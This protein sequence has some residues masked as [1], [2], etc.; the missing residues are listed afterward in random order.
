MLPDSL[1]QKDG[2]VELKD[3]KYVVEGGK[4]YST[5][6]IVW[7]PLY[8]ENEHFVLLSSCIVGVRNGGQE[9]DDWLKNT[10]SNLS[11]TEEETQAFKEIRLL[12]QEDF[13]KT[14]SKENFI[15]SG[16]ENGAEVS[17]WIKNFNVGSLQKVMKKDG[18]I[19]NPGYNARTKS[20][21]VRPVMIIHKDNLL[22]FTR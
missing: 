13:D 9:L 7:V 22:K 16:I 2:V 4:G 14:A 6:N 15:F 10:F 12:S 5:K 1:L 3:C 20:F 19:F 11:F 21:G 18:V 17:W 8:C